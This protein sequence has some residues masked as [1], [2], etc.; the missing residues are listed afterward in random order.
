[1]GESRRTIDIQ[2]KTQSL[3]REIWWDHI[4]YELLKPSE[5]FNTNRYQ[6]QMIDLN[7][8]FQE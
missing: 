8:A 4:C 6:Q 5:T 1:M 2:C 7:R 3:W